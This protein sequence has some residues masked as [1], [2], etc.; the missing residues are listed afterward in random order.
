MDRPAAGDTRDD[1]D[2]IL[3]GAAAGGGELADLAR[4]AEEMRRLVAEPDGDGDDG[5]EDRQLR[6]QTTWA[7]PG[8][9][10]GT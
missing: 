4:L 1:A 7:A 3:L 5:F 2:R 8:D 6:L 9:S 10:T